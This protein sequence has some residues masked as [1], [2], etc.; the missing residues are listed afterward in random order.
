MRRELHRYKALAAPAVAFTGRSDGVALSWWTS[1]GREKK[2][3]QGVSPTDEKNPTK[4]LVTHHP[5]PYP[6]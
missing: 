6:C 4:N 3:R 2:R 1:E 5:R